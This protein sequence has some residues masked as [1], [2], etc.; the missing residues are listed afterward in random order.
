MEQHMNESDA[1]GALREAARRVGSTIL[2]IGGRPDGGQVEAVGSGFLLDIAGSRVLVTAA[3]VLLNPPGPRYLYGPAAMVRIRD[4]W[5]VRAQPGPHPDVDLAFLVPARADLAQ[6]G[7]EQALPFSAEVVVPAVGL[8]DSVTC[9][10]LPVSHTRTRGAGTAL[11]GAMTV[12]TSPVLNPAT[13]L[14]TTRF[15]PDTHFAFHYNQAAVPHLDGTIGRGRS[16]HGMSGGPV[17]L[18]QTMRVDETPLAFL[19]L[20]VC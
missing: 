13:L 17:F 19:H 4:A 14:H 18:P 8:A 20:E 11:Y 15:H 3:H 10:G 1:T 16:L 12:L 5:E 2:P 6:I 7:A 9:F